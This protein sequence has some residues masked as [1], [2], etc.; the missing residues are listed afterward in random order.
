MMRGPAMTRTVT[1]LLL[2]VAGPLIWAGHF[3][4]MYGAQTLFC[5]SAVANDG[6]SFHPYAIT[7]TAAAI[8]TLTALLTSQLIEAGRRSNSADR[9]DVT[10]FLRTISIILGAGALLAV[11]WSAMAAGVLPA[12]SIAA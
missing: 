7:F 4:V 9:S 12:C 8:L 5:M 6:R 11:V 10:Q 2:C 3:S 1:Q